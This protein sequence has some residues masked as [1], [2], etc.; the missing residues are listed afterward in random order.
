MGSAVA[1]PT[2]ALRPMTRADFPDLLRWRTAPH[3]ARWFP[4]AEAGTLELVEA[5]Y[6]PRIDGDVATRMFV[7][8]AHGR[9]VGFLQDY[10]L[11]DHPDY[12]VVTPD[13]HAIGVDYAIGEAAW[14]RRGVGSRM[15]ERWFTV[16]EQGYPGASTLFA[17]PDH[18]NVASRRLLL[19]V[20]FVEGAWFD[21]RQSDGSV[22]TL[23]GH[24]LDVRSVL[25]W[26][27]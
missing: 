20:G 25:G 13:P 14:L 26:R 19:G 11:S 12:A 23:V 7:V 15:L 8:E 4:T 6:G 17:A 16:A 24:T 9:S 21:E 27:P 1:G 5:R 3:V 22:A 18:R 10:R 2:V